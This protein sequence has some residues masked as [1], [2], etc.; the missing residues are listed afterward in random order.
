[1]RHCEFCKEE[2]EKIKQD[3]NQLTY[4]V[5]DEQDMVRSVVEEESQ[6]SDD[7]ES[8][9]FCI[10]HVFGTIEKDEMEKITE[11]LDGEAKVICRRIFKRFIETGS[12]HPDFEGSTLFDLI[13]KVL[14]DIRMNILPQD[15]DPEEDHYMDVLRY[16]S[17]KTVTGDPG[18]V[19]E[20]VSGIVLEK[21][22]ASKGMEDYF[23]RPQ[24]IIV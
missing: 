21:N 7:E 24:V 1:V 12:V 10:R 18:D 11:D 22:L 20:I 17:T 4:M 6:E 15:L 23:V 9:Y 3:L 16:V 14:Y 2:I 5:E 13:T 19:I 8:E